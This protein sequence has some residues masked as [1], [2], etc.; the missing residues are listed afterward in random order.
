MASTIARRDLDEESARVHGLRDRLWALLSDAIPD[1]AVTGHA[2]DRLP[3]TL[4]VRFPNASAVALLARA[5]GV[6][7]STGSACHAGSEKPSG[8]LLSMGIAPEQALGAMAL[9]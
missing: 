6:A 3:N 9:T 2:K 1:L 5:E 8:I 7:A 4:N